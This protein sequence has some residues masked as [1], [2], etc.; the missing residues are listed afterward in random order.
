MAHRLVTLDDIRAAERR[1]DGVAQRTPVE[2]SRACSDAAGVRTLLKCEH[3]QRTGSFKIRGAYNRIV[4]LSDEERAR[5]VVASSAGNHAQG[6]ALSAQLV[7]VDATVFMPASAPL[8]KVEATRGYGADVVL[9]GESYDDAYEAA[10]KW[11]AEHDAVFVH[12]FDHP[13][14]IAGQGTL[15]LELVEQVP[16]IGSVIVPMGGGGLIS[17][18][19]TA[20]KALRPQT[21]VVGVEAAGAAAFPASLAAGQPCGLDDLA[22]IADGIAVKTPGELTLAHVRERVDQVVTVSD[23]AIARAVLLLVER[24][25]QVVEPSGAAGLAAILDTGL[26]LPEPVVVVLGGGNVDPLLLMRIIQSGM[27][28]EGRYLV[29]RTRLEDRPGALSRLLAL[30]ADNGANIVAVEHHRL[31]TR[32]GVL[33]VEVQIELETRGAQHIRHVVA[34]LRASGY[35]VA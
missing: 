12:P 32:L 14:V 10:Q 2:T 29:L 8:P 15:G 1:L 34:T 25:K 17:G 7:G 22:T 30:L 5:G 11:M 4:Q 19:A 18:I 27:F 9:V 3:L 21:V 20:V 35:P 31:G 33:E 13:G 16:D 24:A 28:E 23:E 26:V 6:V